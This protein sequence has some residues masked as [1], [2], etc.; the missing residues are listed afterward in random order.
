[1]FRKTVVLYN[2]YLWL[3]Y[4]S[5]VIIYIIGPFKGTM[6]DNCGNFNK[7]PEIE[8]NIPAGVKDMLA[9]VPPDMQKALIELRK[10]EPKVLA[11]FKEKPELAAKFVTDPASVLATIGVPVDS[12]VRARLKAV[13]S[14]PNFLKPRTFCLPTGKMLNAKVRVSIVGSASDKEVARK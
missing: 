4:S 7:T 12:Q 14:H 10:Y 5:L 2:G 1:L 6:K 9:K 13:S 8:G 11:A 3:L